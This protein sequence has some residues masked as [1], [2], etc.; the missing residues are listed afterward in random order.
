MEEDKESHIHFPHNRVSAMI[1]AHGGE[2]W[3]RVGEGLLT[4]ASFATLICWELWPQ[5]H[6][7]VGVD[8]EV[9]RGREVH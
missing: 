8:R 1:P 7:P 6:R 5:D 4:S 9:V 3:F 2:R